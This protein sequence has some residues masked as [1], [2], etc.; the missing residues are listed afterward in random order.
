[1]AI[2]SKTIDWGGN[3]LI[4]R[5]I[6]LATKP[7]QQGTAATIDATEL[8]FLNAVTAGTATASK[9]VVLGASKE[10]STITTATITNLTSTTVTPTTIAGAANFTGTP[11]LAAGITNT[12]GT[13]T[14]GAGSHVNLDSETAACTGTGGT[15]TATM[16]K[17][18]AQIT[19]ASITTAG[20]AD[21]VITITYTGVAA[22]DLVFITK[23]GGS[24]TAT[25]N[26]SLK[27]VCTT[28]TITVTISNHTAA[29]ALNGTVIF[30]ILRFI[31]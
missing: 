28:N 16:T 6:L 19:T 22:T 10:I 14:L 31:A 9:A 17:D 2:K 3:S 21:H 1:M 27:A 18:A 30:N 8:G 12:T 15:S 24:N 26:Y 4:V 11:T 23:A 7:G 13:I 20:G 29:T 5:E 25:E